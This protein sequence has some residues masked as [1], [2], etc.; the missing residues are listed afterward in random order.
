MQTL[1]WS[2]NSSLTLQTFSLAQ[3]LL[4]ICI[5]RISKRS[6]GKESVLFG[7]LKIALVFEVIG[8]RV[9]NYGFQPANGDCPLCLGMGSCPK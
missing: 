3:I 6:C 8:M 2:C 1:S 9:N 7:K 5:D 4:I